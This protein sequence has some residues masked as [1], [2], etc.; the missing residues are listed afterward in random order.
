MSVWSC[1]GNAVGQPLA[2]FLL[3]LHRKLARHARLG[4]EVPPAPPPRMSVEVGTVAL[5]PRAAC[6]RCDAV[7]PCA[8]GTRRNT[9]HSKVKQGC[10]NVVK[11]DK[12]AIRAIVCGVLADEPCVCPSLT[13][14][15]AHDCSSAC[16]AAPTAAHHTHARW[17]GAGVRHAGTCGPPPPPRWA[18]LTKILLVDVRARWMSAAESRSSCLSLSVS[19]WSCRCRLSRSSVLALMLERSRSCGGGML[20]LWGRR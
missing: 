11:A 12:A 14:A 6:N 4:V 19:S 3:S 20:Q 10:G 7:L 5:K 13:R 17:V 15:T 2:L 16:A 9:P 8:A 1:I 18:A